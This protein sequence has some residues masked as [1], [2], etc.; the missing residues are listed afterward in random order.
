MRARLL[1]LLLLAVTLL[2]EA[3]P[4]GA[5]PPPAARDWKGDPHAMPSSYSWLGNDT[6]SDTYDVA[7]VRGLGARTHLSQS[8]FEGDHPTYVLEDLT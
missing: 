8:W 1:P 7:V 5:D 4:A 2:A 3:V 6:P